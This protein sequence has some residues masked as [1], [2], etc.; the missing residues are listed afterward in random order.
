MHSVVC[1]D[2]GEDLDQIKPIG[3][4]LG[5][6]VLEGCFVRPRVYLSNVV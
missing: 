6:K 1:E 4:G 5:L 3:L 2:L